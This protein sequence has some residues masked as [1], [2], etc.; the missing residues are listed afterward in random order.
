M[1]FKNWFI[2]HFINSLFSCRLFRSFKKRLCSSF[3]LCWSCFCPDCSSFFL[4]WSCFCP[5]CSSF[6]LCWSCFCPACSWLLSDCPY[7]FFYFRSFCSLRFI[8]FFLNSYL[9]KL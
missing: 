9:C 1:S 8:S 6:F 3:F 7:F 4:C 5:D 2:S